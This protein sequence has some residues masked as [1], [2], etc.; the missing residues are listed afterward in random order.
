MPVRQQTPNQTV[1]RSFHITVGVA[2]SQRAD[3]TISL[4]HERELVKA[5]LLYGDRAAL[6]SPTCTILLSMAMR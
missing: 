6:C 1:T 5:A 2:A 3:G 4:E